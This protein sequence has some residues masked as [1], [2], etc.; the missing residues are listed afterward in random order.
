MF[1]KPTAVF[2]AGLF[3]PLAAAWVVEM[4]DKP[5]INP[6]YDIDGQLRLEP[7][8]RNALPEKPYSY[9]HWNSEFIPD[10]C[11]DI[12]I[13]WQ[14]NPRDID[15]FNIT[16]PDCSTPWVLCRHKRSPVSEQAIIGVSHFLTLLNISVYS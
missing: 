10:I 1:F 7:A 11:R 13:D 8:L 14:H 4:P 3:A 15:V 5:Y 6:V 16:Y 12:A 9:A 2:A